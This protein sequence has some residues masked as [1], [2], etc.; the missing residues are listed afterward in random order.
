[1]VTTDV[2]S[3]ALREQYVDE[4]RAGGELRSSRWIEAFAQVPREHF[5]PQFAVPR[6]NGG[7]A[8]FTRNDPDAL[9]AVYSDAALITRWDAAGVPTSS[10]SQPRLMANM[11]ER[12]DVRPG[13][14]VLEI[15]TGT[16][17]NAAL[18]CHVLGSDAVTSVDLDE[19]VAAQAADRLRELGCTP[20]ITVAEASVGA[21]ERGPFDRVIGTCGFTRVPKAWLSQ[22]AED[23]VLVLTLGC[24][25]VVLHGG[26]GGLSG[27]V[28]GPA[29]FMSRGSVDDVALGPREVVRIADEL[30]AAERV[31]RGF[32]R[33]TFDE[34]GF[35][36]LRTLHFPTMREVRRHE[37][38]LLTYCLHD[39]VREVSTR[40]DVRGGT[41]SVST[42]G[43]DLWEELLAVEQRWR[44][45]GCPDLARF[46]VSVH[47][48]G[49][50]DLWLDEPGVVV[51]ALP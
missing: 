9:T 5:V 49:S 16:G 39:P 2:D 40:A 15:G 7:F 10:S 51:S 35:R 38:E 14:R 36:F 45:H 1:M 32:D 28:V 24:G 37:D 6:K 43:G 50:H 33:E 19:S 29:S 13:H 42:R 31:V 47:S 20:R 18:L 25:L 41:A 46:G 11:L 48:D 4:L 23:S 26:P 22:L 44:E 3:A 17:Y 27:R 8:E 30:P 12:L 34:W 21:P